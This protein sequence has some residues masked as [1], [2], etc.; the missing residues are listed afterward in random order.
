MCLRQ[1]GYHHGK[2]SEEID[3]EI[4]QVVMRVMGADQKQTDRHAEQ[5]LLRWGVLI[6]VVDLL[7]QI[8]VVESPSVEVERDSAHMVEHEVGTEHV[9]D[10]GQGPGQ[11]L[12]GGER[13]DV[14]EDL[15][16][17]DENDVDCPCTLMGKLARQGGGSEG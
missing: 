12:I 16:T 14:E 11:L 3:H 13:E 2:S 15:Q 10:V 17:D 4:R 6:P 1:L 5:E 9:G 7:P 8:Q